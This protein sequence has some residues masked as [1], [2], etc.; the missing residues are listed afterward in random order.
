MSGAHITEA[1]R[2]FS[3]ESPGFSVFVHENRAGGLACPID[4]PVGETVEP[5]LLREPGDGRT[6]AF[7]VIDDDAGGVAPHKPGHTRHKRVEERIL[8]AA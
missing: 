5:G 8:A 3:R 4:G 7:P 6:F 1:I 2:F